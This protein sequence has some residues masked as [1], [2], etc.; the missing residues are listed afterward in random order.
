MCHHTKSTKADLDRLSKNALMQGPGRH[1][2]SRRVKTHSGAI[3][4]PR[5][6]RAVQVEVGTIGGTGRVR[7][8]RDE[9]GPLPDD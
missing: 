6:Y 9:Q 8:P 2:L 3:R 1:L 5:G 7:G 4:E